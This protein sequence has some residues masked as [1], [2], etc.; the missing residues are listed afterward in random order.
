MQLNKTTVIN[1]DIINN[2]IYNKNTICVFVIRSESVKI[3]NHLYRIEIFF[4]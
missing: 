2:L 4:I 1:K 3:I